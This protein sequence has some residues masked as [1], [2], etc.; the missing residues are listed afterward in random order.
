VST[1][2][3]WQKK[4]DG[5]ATRTQTHRVGPLVIIDTGTWP[6]EDRIAYRDESEAERIAL[7]ERYAGPLPSHPDPLGIVAI[8]IVSPLGPPA[9]DEEFS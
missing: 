5:L 7:E 1:W 2:K 4:L 3:E 8:V 6:L 9:D